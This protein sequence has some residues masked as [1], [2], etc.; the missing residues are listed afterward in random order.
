[1]RLDAVFDILGF[2][3]DFLSSESNRDCQ[4]EG[5]VDLKKKKNKTLG[6]YLY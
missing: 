5:K 1:M 2:V 4:G 3:R 6:F